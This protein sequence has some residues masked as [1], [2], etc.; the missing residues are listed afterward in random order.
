MIQNPQALSD[1]FSMDRF[2]STWSGFFVLL[3]SAIT[4]V[5]STAGLY[6]L[7]AFTVAQRTREIGVRKALGA[8][9]RIAASSTNRWNSGCGRVGRDL[10]SG[11]TRRPSSTRLWVRSHLT[12]KSSSPTREP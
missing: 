1:V 12:K 4:I 5:L 6:A 8:T 3:L 9:R 11:W 10:S 7:M 2:A